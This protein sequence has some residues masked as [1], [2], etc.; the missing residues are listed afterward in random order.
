MFKEYMCRVPDFKLLILCKIRLGTTTDTK[1]FFVFTKVR[2]K[3]YFLFIP[4]T[5]SD[6]DSHKSVIQKAC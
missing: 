2:Y 6:W 1:Y 4:G 5:C 3:L